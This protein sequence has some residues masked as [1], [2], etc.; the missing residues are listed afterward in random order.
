VERHVLGDDEGGSASSHASPIEKPAAQPWPRTPCRT[1]SNSGPRRHAFSPF[2]WTKP[3]LRLL[4][5]VDF[6][7]FAPVA[8][9][10]FFFSFF[11]S[12]LGNGLQKHLALPGNAPPRISFGPQPRRRPFALLLGARA[13]VQSFRLSP[14]AVVNRISSP[15][16]QSLASGKR[17]R[18]IRL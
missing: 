13:A 10:F 6:G 15:H 17:R 4:P 3:I 16:G 12:F 8:F 18:A 7:E 11:F 2:P 9:A 14:S 1:G 5:G